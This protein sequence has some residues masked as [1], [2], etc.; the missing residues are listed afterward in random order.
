MDSCICHVDDNA[1]TARCEACYDEFDRKAAPDGW[2]NPQE[3]M[4]LLADAER[5]RN[6]A[7]WVASGRPGLPF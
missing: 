1:W 6:A 7:E 5:A 4:L 3:R 2:A